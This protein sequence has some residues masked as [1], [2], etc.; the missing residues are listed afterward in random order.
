ML[1]TALGGHF[2]WIT[3]RAAG[4][5]ALLTS[6]LSVGLGL[7]MSGRLLKGRMTDLRVAHEALALATIGA[8][9]VHATAL[10]GDSFFH[11]SLAAITVPFVSSY[12]QPW[13]TMGI[14]AGW[15]MIILG[16]SFYARGRIGQQ[17]WRK[18]HRF[19]ALAW[20]LGLGHSL[21]EGTDAGQAWF[22]I[23]TAVVAIPAA[24]LLA[25]RYSAEPAPTPSREPAR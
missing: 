1:A 14:I 4:T 11:P 3:S 16:L 10:L 25:G 7:L 19:T 17:R 15:M 24:L 22:L 6:S 8:I 18:L 23:A 13:M 9:V 21:G 5:A 2:L 20:V 12:K